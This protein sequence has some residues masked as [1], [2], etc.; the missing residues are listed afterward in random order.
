MSGSKKWDDSDDQDGIRPESITVDLYANGD[1]VDS[2]TVTEEDGWKWTF[3]G[4]P[5]YDGG[6]E[7]EYTMS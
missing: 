5:K 7:I 4:L 3:E 2:V 6:D 1:K